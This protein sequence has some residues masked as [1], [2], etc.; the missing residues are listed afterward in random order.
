MAT[1]TGTMPLDG[2]K[3][4]KTGDHDAFLDVIEAQFKTG[5]GV[6]QLTFST[7]EKECHL[8]FTN[9]KGKDVLRDYYRLD[10][11]DRSDYRRAELRRKL[12]ALQYLGFEIESWGA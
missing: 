1:K 8:G 11:T 12:E 10:L 4:V 3:N 2:L 7:D 5:D 6:I 9:F